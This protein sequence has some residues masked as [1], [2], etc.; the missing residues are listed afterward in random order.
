MPVKPVALGL[1]GCY[2]SFERHDQEALLGG[3]MRIGE[4]YKAL[5][6]VYVVASSEITDPRDCTVYLI[7]LGE[8]VLI[9]AGAGPS[10][11]Q[12]KRNIELLGLDPGKLSSVVLT[13]CHIDH[14]GGAQFFVNEFGARLIMHE[15]DAA[16][17]ERGDGKMTAASWYGLRSDPVLIDVKITGEEET[18]SFS[19]QALVCL[20]TPGHTPG[21]LSVYMDRAG[22]RVLFGQDIHGPFHPDFGSDIALWRKSMHHLLQLQADVLCE[23]HFGVYEPKERVRAYIEHYLATYEKS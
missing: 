16:P 13:H 15:A 19:G 20:H 4:P 21:S 9:D 1:A 8:L 7:D 12:I 18:I 2:P 5:D 6:D 14:C 23:G 17:V 3:T 10:A 22:K 11:S